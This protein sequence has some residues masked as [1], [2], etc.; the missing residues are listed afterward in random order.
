M[1]IVIRTGMLEVILGGVSVINASA[2]ER[3]GWVTYLVLTGM[4]FGLEYW[5][6]YLRSV[7][8]LG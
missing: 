7:L 2:I 1:P 3:F 6:L 4:L 5:R 8:I